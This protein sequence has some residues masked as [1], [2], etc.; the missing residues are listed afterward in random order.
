[1]TERIKMFREK[2]RSMD[3]GDCLLKLVAKLI[4][5]IAR[6]MRECLVSLSK[7]FWSKLQLNVHGSSRHFSK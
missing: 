7:F 4:L 6:F 2:N 1:M 3:Y 5:D